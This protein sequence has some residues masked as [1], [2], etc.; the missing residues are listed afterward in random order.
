MHTTPPT[1]ATT[2]TA[3]EQLLTDLLAD[4]R[5]RGDRLLDVKQVAQRTTLCRNTIWQLEREGK[6]PPRRQVTTNKVAWL[7]SD[8]DTWIATRPTAQAARMASG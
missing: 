7:E 4:L 3:L 2:R 8:I 6:F 1:P 5:R